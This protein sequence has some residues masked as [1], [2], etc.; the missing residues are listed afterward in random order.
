MIEQRY[1]KATPEDKHVIKL[2]EHNGVFAHSVV[3]QSRQVISQ[4]IVVYSEWKDVELELD[5]QGV[6]A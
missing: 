3:L 1:R 2:W 4:P 5:E 6:S